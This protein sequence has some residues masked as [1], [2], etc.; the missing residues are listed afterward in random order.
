M[1]EI[2]FEKPFLLSNLEKENVSDERGIYLHCIKLKGEYKI[3]YVGKCDS[4]IS[5]QSDHLAY[6]KN[7]EYSLFVIEDKELNIR[8]IPNYDS[9]NIANES[10]I[11]QNIQNI[12]VFFG[13]I[14]NANG[15]K[16]KSIEG[17]IINCL[18]RKSSTRKFLL[19]I[20]HDYSLINQRIQLYNK[21]NISGLEQIINTTFSDEEFYEKQ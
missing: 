20:T 7:K 13:K 10:L 3:I 8:Y 17:A 15:I 14:R 4:F 9:E 18:W 19:N 12:H 5:R 21:D 16:L 6:Y 11:N 1:I 2:E